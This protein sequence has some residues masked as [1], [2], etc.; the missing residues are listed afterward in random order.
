M[1]HDNHPISLFTRHP[2][3]ANCI[4]IF[5][6]VGGL[7]M[8]WQMRQELFPD[9]DIGVIEVKVEYPGASPEDVQQGV[10]L[11]ME[12]TLRGISEVKRVSCTAYEG[13]ALIAL[14][15]M[16][17]VD[18][19]KVL[20]DVENKISGITTLPKEAEA[21][22]VTLIE[23]HQ[24]VISLIIHGDE[25]VGLLRHLAEQMRTELLDLPDVTDVE[26]DPDDPWLIA[27]EVPSSQLRALG[28][29]LDQIAQ[30][31]K[32]AALPPVGGRISTDKGDILLSSPPSPKMPD[33]FAQIPLVTD[34]EGV[35]VLLGEVATIKNAFEEKGLEASFNGQKAFRL[36]I[37]Q[38]ANQRP[39]EVANAVRRYADAKRIALPPNIQID[40]WDWYAKAFGGRA[41]LL[42]KNGFYALLVVLTILIV[43]LEPRIAFWVTMGIPVSILGSF[44]ILALFPSMTLNMISIF[45]FILT[46]GI[47]VD[48]AVVVGEIIFLHD[49]QGKGYLESAIAGTREVA[50]PVTF[51]VAT[52]MAAFVPLLFVPGTSGKLFAQIPLITIAVFLVSLLEALFILPAHLAVRPHRRRPVDLGELPNQTRFHILQWLLKSLYLPIARRLITHRYLTVA[53]AVGLLLIAIGIVRGGHLSF[54]YVPRIDA[55]NVL[56]QAYLPFGAP[57]E[58]ARRVEQALVKGAHTVLD[59]LGEPP[60]SLGVYTKIGTPLFGAGVPVWTGS[61]VPDT[62]IVGTEV[63]LVPLDERQISAQEFADL[64]RQEIGNL[65]GIQSLSFNATIGTRSGAALDVQLAHPDPKTLQEAASRLRDVLLSYS[66][67]LDLDVGY[68]L[69][70][71]QIN[72]ELTPEGRALGLTVNDLARQIRAAFYGVESFRQQRGNDEVKVLVRLPQNERGMKFTV[73]NTILRTPSGGEIALK[74]AADF[75]LGR[76]Y[77][78]IQRADGRQVLHVS[79]DVDSRKDDVNTILQDITDTIMPRLEQELPG[80]TYSIEGQMREQI[81]ALAN[82]KFGFCVLLFVL[83]ALLAIP[84][85][86]YTQPLIILAV[87]PF[88]LIGAILGHLL[89][90]YELSLMSVFGI[91]ALSGVVINDSLLLIV[92][93]NRFRDGTPERT[94]L[95]AV[96]TRFRPVILTTLTTFGGLSPLMLETSLQARFLIPMAISISFG[97]LFATFITLFLMPALYAVLEDFTQQYTDRHNMRVDGK[98][99]AVLKRRAEH[100]PR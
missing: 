26:I 1:I 42:I 48:D 35:R 17:N 67:I 68:S 46:L 79:A 55:D 54:S 65:V 27:I 87:I 24:E 94:M 44:L 99:A 89:L 29:T 20:L 41:K 53:V 49:Q 61:P 40:T 62:H 88:G 45:A 91:I 80:L 30:K 14:E 51:A 63:L 98:Q 56:C 43:F 10:L 25:E 22:I 33:E 59:R 97:V 7:V 66:G 36:N 21:P 74:E 90:G 5:L 47:I 18:P 58:E 60:I 16:D 12:T 32:E 2:V 64:W 50:M 86:N 52:N 8:A 28:L 15:L 77:T 76:S 13:L 82:L 19:N 81:E 4:M 34:A 39:L 96:A 92:T 84:L 78:N 9:Y 38:E 11:T 75:H 6:L 85:R 69:G 70:K 71:P 31:I 93:A 73:E 95:M 57:I 23:G 72:L 100:N 83:Y 37:F 3:A